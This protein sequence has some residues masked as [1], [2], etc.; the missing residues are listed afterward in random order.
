MKAKL[1]LL[2]GINI[3]LLL[4]RL[5][6]PS[7]LKLLVLHLSEPSARNLLIV[8]LLLLV[9]RQSVDGRVD[10]APQGL[11]DAL[12]MFSIMSDRQDD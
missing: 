10:V 12:G 3:A 9:A 1:P 6:Q 5:I 8:R 7:L 4:Q 11:A 2:L